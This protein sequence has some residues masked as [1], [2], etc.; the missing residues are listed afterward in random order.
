METIE[1][2]FEN[3][4]ASYNEETPQNEE[5][6]AGFEAF[7]KILEKLFPCDISITMNIYAEATESKKKESFSNLQ[8]KIKI[9]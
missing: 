6:I 5:Q 8:E 7:N 1:T 4:K 3:Y 2:I 9:S